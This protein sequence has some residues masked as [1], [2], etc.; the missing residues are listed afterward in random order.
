VFASHFLSADPNALP[1]SYLSREI[2]GDRLKDGAG[3]ISSRAQRAIAAGS[4]YAIW[5]VAAMQKRSDI[6][7]ALE[8][9]PDLAF[10]PVNLGDLPN[11]IVVT[12]CDNCSEG[13]ASVWKDAF[14][15]NRLVHVAAPGIDVLAPV[16]PGRF[17]VAGGTSQ[18]TAIVGGLVGAMINCYPRHYRGNSAQRE[19]LSNVVKERL[20][21]TSRPIF[22]E[23]DDL[24][25]LAAG[26]V[27]PQAA[28][29][30]PGKTWVKLRGQ[31]D[32]T[33]LSGD[34][35]LTHWCQ[36]KIVLVDRNGD[37]PDRP[38]S[39]KNLLRMVRTT[40]PGGILGNEKP[41][42]LYSLR[43]VEPRGIDRFEPRVFES[44]EMEDEPIARKKNGEFLHPVDFDDLIL[45]ATLRRKQC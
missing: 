18:A 32:Y 1:Y 15:S 16:G 4:D 41:W 43:P 8:V 21:Y 6:P 11:V 36:D 2:V 26:V 39:T 22:Y 38:P 42:V 29:L 20:Q 14:F 23:P 37:A 24:K 10:S 5:V 17:A 45:S 3:R 30:D 27:D 12:A 44:P 19:L 9:E 28:L 7:D 25:R 33:E 35:E 31:R 40:V 13:N 34:D